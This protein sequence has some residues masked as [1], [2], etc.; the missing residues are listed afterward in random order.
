MGCAQANP[1]TRLLAYAYDFIIPFYSF[2]SVLVLH[3]VRRSVGALVTE[4]KIEAQADAT[5]S[6]MLRTPTLDTQ[7]RVVVGRESGD[8][9]RE[10]GGQR[11]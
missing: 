4:A 1:E 8:L 7:T 9:R 3:G 10:G 2:V 11:Q 5:P 6:H